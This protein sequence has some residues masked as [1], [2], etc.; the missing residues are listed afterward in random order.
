[1]DP[2][3]QLIVAIKEALESDADERKVDIEARALKQH[4]SCKAA[5]QL[6]A[7]FPVLIRPV[8]SGH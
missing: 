2:K 7:V 6:R 8:S 5:D 3:S 1:L 4:D